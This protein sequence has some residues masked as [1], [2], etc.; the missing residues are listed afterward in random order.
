MAPF[1]VTWDYLCPFARNAHEHLLAGLDGGAAWDVTFSPFSLI[2]NHVAEG[3]P[4]I[5]DA[6]NHAAGLKGLLALQAGVVVRDRFPDQFHQVHRD[7][8]AARHDDGRDLADPAVVTDVLDRAGVPAATVL[9]AVD[10]GWPLDEIRRAHEASVKEH[11][12]FGVPT[13]VIDDRAVFV[14]LM[15]RPDGDA[16][17]A[18]RTIDAV[19]DLIVERPEINEF[20]YTSIPR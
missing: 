2:Q 15:S 4:P 9:A 16:D 17:L 10:D 6:P 12:V 3:E 7:L 14:R 11:Q 5:W 18:R 19:V 20:K 13:F 8:F 1:S